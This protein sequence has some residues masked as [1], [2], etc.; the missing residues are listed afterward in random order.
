MIPFEGFFGICIKFVCPAVFLY[1]M[2]ESLSLDLAIPF[3][4]TSAE[5]QC[6]AS[7]PVFLTVLII[8]GPMFVCDWPER[9]NYDVN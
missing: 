3:G 6:I 9:F 8:F 7:I 4:S 5:I 2:S 1:M